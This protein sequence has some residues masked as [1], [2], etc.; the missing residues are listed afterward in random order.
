MNI[1]HPEFLDFLKC[2]QRNKL[3]YLCIGGYAVNYY[4]YHR[5]TQDLDI[6]IAPT[7]VNKE[8]FFNTLLCMGYTESEFEDIRKEDFTTYFM[9][10]LGARPNVIDVVTILHRSLNFDEAEKNMSLHILGDDIELRLV[11][12]ESLKETKLYSFRPKD[13]WDLTQLEKLRTTK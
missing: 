7:N 4:G 9:C 3:R 6:W 1:E 13:T 12:Y 5:M 2:A 10:T 11:S 8:C